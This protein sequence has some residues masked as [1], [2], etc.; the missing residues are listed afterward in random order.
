VLEHPRAA[1]PPLPD[2]PPDDAPDEARITYVFGVLR[3]DSVL[4]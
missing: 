3:D 2:L 1:L 4:F